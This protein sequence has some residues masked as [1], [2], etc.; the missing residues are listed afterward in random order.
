MK[1]HCIHRVV[2]RL[3][4][5]LALCSLYMTALQVHA[6]QGGGAPQESASATNSFAYTI[7]NP[8]GPNAVEAFRRNTRTGRLTHI[9][10]FPTDGTGDPFVGAFQQHSLASHGRFL[11]AVN[12]GSDTITAFAINADGSLEH[13]GTVP[14]NGRRP[15]S[16]AVHGQ[17]LYVANE[18]SIPGEGADT[19][20]YS[21]FHIRPNGT[22]R[23]IPDST[24]PVSVGGSLADVLFNERGDLLVGTRLA[25]NI[26]D[27]FRVGD[28][29]R[30]TD[31]K[32]VPGSGGPFGAVFN[33]AKPRQLLVSLAVPEVF[34]AP[35]PGVALYILRGDGTLS[36]RDV[37]TDNALVDPCWI[38]ITP[39]GSIFWTSSFIPR[40]LVAFALSDDGHITQLSTYDPQD[41]EPNGVVIGSS[42]I[43]LDKA[44]AFLYQLR[45][46]SVPDGETAVVPR[47]HVFRVTGQWH[48]N[49]GLELVQEL[50]LPRDLDETGIIGLLL[51][52]RP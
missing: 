39:N 2:V 23:P 20:S 3:A 41:R 33:P 48:V 30:L 44:G 29:G 16:L 46:F 49:A 42:D 28:D 37:I 7:T 43:A 5:V 24:I 1:H 14:S 25:G 10:R 32:T 38:A 17:L 36:R 51:V 26:I 52:D 50:D 27:S 4:C 40:T 22:L 19:A 34:G 8:D 13:L 21:G 11:Y 12:P 18:G 15:V 45:A 31:H 35:A 47:L 9:G 6:E